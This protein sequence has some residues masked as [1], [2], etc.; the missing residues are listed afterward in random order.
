MSSQWLNMVSVSFVVVSVN[1]LLLSFE[2]LLFVLWFQFELACMILS[3]PL[4]GAFPHFRLSHVIPIYCWQLF[5]YWILTVVRLI[6]KN[7]SKQAIWR[8]I[9][10]LYQSALSTLPNTNYGLIIFI[11]YCKLELNGLWFV[12]N[13]AFGL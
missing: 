12:L 2:N 13:S 9:A 3:F 4:V 7:Y 1:L 10:D 5:S 11:A 6:S 8:Y